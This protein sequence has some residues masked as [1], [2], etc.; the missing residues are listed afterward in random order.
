MKWIKYLLLSLTSG[1]FVLSCDK[2]HAIDC[3]E[4]VEATGTVQKTALTTYQ[5]GTHTIAGYALR[6]CSVF[7]EDYVDENIT[8]IGIKFYGYPVDGGPIY[9]EVQ[10]VQ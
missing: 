2:D 5:Y 4:E 9:L 6:S 3:E 1:L 8:I 10:A 7:L